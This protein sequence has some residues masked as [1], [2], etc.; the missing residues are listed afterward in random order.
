MGGCDPIGCPFDKTVPGASPG[1][2]SDVFMIDDTKKL[3][4]VPFGSTCKVDKGF[5]VD[6]GA[7]AEGVIIDCSAKQQKKQVQQLS[8]DTSQTQKCGNTRIIVENVNGELKLQIRHLNV[9]IPYLQFGII[10]KVAWI[11]YLLQNF[12]KAVI[13]DRD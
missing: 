5:I 3:R 12:K 13:Q 10:S 4:Q 8:V 6:N 11:G 7:A 1:R 9:L 2:A